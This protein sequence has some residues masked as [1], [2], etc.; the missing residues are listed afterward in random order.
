MR[1][2]S[3]SSAAETKSAWSPRAALRNMRSYAS[4]T[5]APSNCEAYDMSITTGRRCCSAVI[6]GSFACV[7]M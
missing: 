1:H 6:P 3:T 5:Y 4:P 7:I 2:A